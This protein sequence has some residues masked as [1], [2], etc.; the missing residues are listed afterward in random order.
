VNAEGLAVAPGGAAYVVTKSVLGESS[1]YAVPEKPDPSQVQTLRV[2][3]G[4]R[5]AL[6]G[7]P[8]GP[9]II[10]QLTA[11]GAALSSDGRTLAVRTYTDAY[12]WPVSDGN[13]AAALRASPV[14]IAL[15]AQSLG[16]GIAIS[17][18][19]LLVDSEGAGSTVY[20]VPVPALAVPSRSAA[21]EA[22]NAS[23]ASTDRAPT[24]TPARHPWYVVAVVLLVVV[25]IAVIIV[26]RRRR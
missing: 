5:F 11:T 19:T 9:P 12:L 20:A 16:E 22:A 2:V 17:G 21:P 8:G 14:R 18:S 26:R 10:G 4:I 7:T 24:A 1:V 13:V 23:N 25:G 3:G 6:T 15:P